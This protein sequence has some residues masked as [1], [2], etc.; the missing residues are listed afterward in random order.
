MG[1]DADGKERRREDIAYNPTSKQSPT[2]LVA[3][4]LIRQYGQTSILRPA[5]GTQARSVVFVSRQILAPVRAAGGAR[6][7]GALRR[8]GGLGLSTSCHDCEKADVGSLTPEWRRREGQV[9]TSWRGAR[10]RCK[11]ERLGVIWRGLRP[12]PTLSCAN[13]LRLWALPKLRIRVHFISPARLR[14][15]RTTL[16]TV[17]DSAKLPSSSMVPN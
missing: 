13:K 10:R 14:L 3:A 5:R 9:T 11:N 1:R 8:R 6:A 12:L 7:H 17:L 15:R 2:P 4:S 16:C